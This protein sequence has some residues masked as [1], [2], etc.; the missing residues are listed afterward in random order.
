MSVWKGIAQDAL[1]MNLDDVFCCGATGP[2]LVT[3][4]IGRNRRLVPGYVLVHVCIYPSSIFTS[5]Q[6]NKIAYSEI[7]SALIH[8]L[9]EACAD[10]R[11][12]GIDVGVAGG[13]T[14][15][16]GDLVRT[17]TFDCT[18]T[19]RVRRSQVI[20][21]GRIG[22][23]DWIV[24]LASADAGTGDES[25]DWLEG[26][27]SGIGANGLT[28][29]RHDVLEHKLSRKYPESF[30]PGLPPHLVYS[31]GWGLTEPVPPEYGAPPGTTIGQLLLSPTR[32]Y[33]P[34]LQLLLNED[35]MPLRD[36]IHGLVHCSGGGQ[37]KALRCL[38]PSR[39][40]LRIV[41]DALFETPGVFRLIHAEQARLQAAAAGGGGAAEAELW[42]EMYQVFNMGHRLELYTSDLNAVRTVVDCA[43][44]YGFDAHVVGQVEEAPP[45]ATGHSLV[46]RG[47]HG[48]FVYT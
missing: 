19:T 39:P 35:D 11:P 33:A 4:T 7:V 2:A 10:L 40:P 31:G 22:P 12:R 43:M 44:D 27:T 37:T 47:A 1:T 20:D 38:D 9:E 46:I 45:G 14:A 30:D 21:N 15:D 8:G 34:L 24:G 13:E 26:W 16:I 18:Y 23:G 5:Y 41:K 6:S 3:S 48:E 42:R 17:V 29:A 28:A 36:T 25:S 32:T